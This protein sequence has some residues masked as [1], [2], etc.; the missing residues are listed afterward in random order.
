MLG[1]LKVSP[2]AIKTWCTAPVVGSL[3]IPLSHM[4]PTSVPQTPNRLSVLL[5]GKFPVTQLTKLV[6]ALSCWPGVGKAGCG[7]TAAVTAA[8]GLVLSSCPVVVSAAAAVCG[9]NAVSRLSNS[10]RANASTDH[11]SVGWVGLPFGLKAQF[12]TPETAFT[13]AATGFRGPVVVGAVTFGVTRCVVV[14]TAAVAALAVAAVTF[15]A[16]GATADT[17][18]GLGAEGCGSAAG[19]RA[20]DETVGLVSGVAAVGRWRFGVLVDVCAGSVA[21]LFFG[22]VL[23]SRPLVGGL[24]GLVSV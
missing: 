6:D 1:P 20:G 8:R 10:L 5:G 24:S 13:T 17:V 3:A 4:V 15:T 16:S 14:V 11:A 12:S 21:L 9:L 7:F 2:K 23:P 22:W 18:T 19:L